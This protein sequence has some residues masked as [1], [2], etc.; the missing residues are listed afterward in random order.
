MLWVKTETRSIFELLFYFKKLSFSSCFKTIHYYYYYSI[1]LE[2]CLCLP[3]WKVVIRLLHLRLKYNQVI[4]YEVCKYFY[5]RTIEGYCFKML[6]ELIRF[7]R[8]WF[9]RKSSLK[10]ASFYINH[11]LLTSGDYFIPIMQYSTWS[12]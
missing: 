3:L 11:S 9:P 8:C 12:W 1:L 6:T 4:C 5:A 7:L 10:L 2:S